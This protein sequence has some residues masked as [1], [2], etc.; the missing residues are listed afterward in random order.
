MPV[1]YAGKEIISSAGRNS[2]GRKNQGGRHGK[3]GCAED[4]GYHRRYEEQ[5]YSFQKIKY[6]SLVEFLHSW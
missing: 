2:L 1:G 5:P 4:R 3:H 6:Q